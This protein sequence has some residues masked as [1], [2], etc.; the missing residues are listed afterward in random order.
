MSRLDEFLD[1]NEPDNLPPPVTEA[2]PVEARA[3][4]EPVAKPEPETP[5]A[6]LLADGTEDT[7]NFRRLREVV[8]TTRKERNDH[9]GRADRA[10]GEAA[11]LRAEVEALRKAPA[12][13]VAPPP[14]QPAVAAQPEYV[15]NPMEDPEGFV[16]FQ[17]RKM[18]DALFHQRLNTSEAFL[19]RFMK[20]NADVDAKVEVFKKAAA[21]NPVLGVELRKHPDPYQ[22]AYETAQRILAQQE[23]GTDPA[24]YRARVEAE[25]R[26]K[27][28]AEYAANQPAQQAARVALPRSLS[29][30]PSAAPRGEVVDNTPV[31]FDDILRRNKRRNA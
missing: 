8:I 19:R 31:D 3:E 21:E 1:A 12:P 7:P 6:D 17:A 10:E 14:A 15:P 5:E 28:E 9:K 11:A 2:A 30:V 25:I 26:A 4:P 13:P 29:T 23:I 18:D 20:D 24:A 22:Y 27:V 16:Q